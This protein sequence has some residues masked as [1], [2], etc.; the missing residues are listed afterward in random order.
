M[1]EVHAKQY[2]GTWYRI[3]SFPIRWL[4]EEFIQS[5][6]GFKCHTVEYRIISLIAC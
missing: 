4:A 1:Y 2:D 3:G 6:G 5:R